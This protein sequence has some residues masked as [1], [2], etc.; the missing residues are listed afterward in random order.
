VD[1]RVER[2]VAGGLAKRTAQTRAGKEWVERN[3]W[4]AEGS[5]RGKA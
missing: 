3:P 5:T 4:W 1:E 2:Y